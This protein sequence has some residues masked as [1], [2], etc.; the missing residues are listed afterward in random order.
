[1]ASVLQL[2]WLLIINQ[3]D[4]GPLYGLADYCMVGN[5]RGV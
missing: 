1:M 2:T 3:F 5:F 4:A